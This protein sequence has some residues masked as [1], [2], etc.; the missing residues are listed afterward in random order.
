MFVFKNI[1]EWSNKKLRWM[2]IVFN[3][4]YFTMMAIIPAVIICLEY[5]LFEVQST[6]MKLTG[7]GLILVIVLGLY[8]YYKIREEINKLPQV[9]YNHQCIKFGLQLLFSL[10]P[11]GLILFGFWMVRTDI[12]VAYDTMLWCLLSMFLSDIVDYGFLKFIQ[13]EREIREDALYDKE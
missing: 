12:Q 5:K 8:A 11:K 10:M 9:K 3:L 13:V 4:L 7:V 1:S 2:S 6:A